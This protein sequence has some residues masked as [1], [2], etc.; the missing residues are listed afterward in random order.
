MKINFLLIALCIHLYAGG[1]SSTISPINANIKNR[2][3]KGNSWKPNCPVKLKDLRYLQMSYIDFSGNSKTG[4]M[5]V[6]KNVA[7][8]V[9]QIFKTLYV[10]KYPIRKM[11][12]ISHYHGNDYRS[13]EADNTSAFNCRAVTGNKNKWSKH[14]YGKAIDINPIEN[15]YISKRGNCSHKK[16]K[17]YLTPKRVYHKNATITQRAVLLK[18]AE[19]VKAFKKFGWR[20]GGDWK[21][22]KDYQ[23][24]D[25][26]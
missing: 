24:F 12:L 9:V 1:Y 19:A 10:N 5:I 21:H 8:D 7:D 17:P 14:A 11:N 15:P 6:H 26:K 3:V 18:K 22:I 23:H 2:M 4:E 25:K 16:S 20:W 13:I